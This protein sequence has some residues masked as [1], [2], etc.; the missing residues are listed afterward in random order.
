M[1]PAYEEGKKIAAD[2]AAAGKFLHKNKMTGEIIVV[3]DAS[4]DN[5]TNAAK[6][7]VDS[8][9]AEINLKVLHY[10]QHRGK[11]YAVREGVRESTGLYV[12]FADS[13][14]CVPYDNALKGL[15][16]IESGLCDIAHGSRKMAESKIVKKQTFYR[17][18][19]SMA[20]GLLAAFMMGLPKLT[21]T[22]CGFKIYR[23]DIARNLYG[24]CLTDGF[25]FDLEIIM[26]ALKQGL[27]IKEFAVEWRCDLDSRLKPGRN[28]KQVISELLA[29]KRKIK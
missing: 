16:L 17:R 3:D 28:M 9:P 5:T 2:I 11:G 7:A 24:Q 20:F 21:D 1:I 15:D 25:M 10:D 18:L 6:E 4:T 12:M 27:R 13:G 26:R 19:G 14:G 8:I 22:Q 23:G 29:I